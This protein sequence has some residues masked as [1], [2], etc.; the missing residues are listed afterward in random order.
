MGV[1]F[2]PISVDLGLQKGSL[3]HAVPGGM[4]WGRGISGRDVGPKEEEWLHKKAPP[5]GQQPSPT[6]ERSSCMERL[7]FLHIS[8]GTVSESGADLFVYISNHLSLCLCLC[9]YLYDALIPKRFYNR[10][11][12]NKTEHGTHCRG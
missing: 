1:Q 9:I 4:V 7:H 8:S 11:N 5:S 12:N 3:T 10:I 2:S 6:E